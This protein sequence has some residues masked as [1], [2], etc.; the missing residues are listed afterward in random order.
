MHIKEWNL[1]QKG[2]IIEVADLE[3]RSIIEELSLLHQSS[4]STLATSF[5][6]KIKFLII[7]LGYRLGYCGYANITKSI[8]TEKLITLVNNEIDKYRQHYNFGNHRFRNTEWLFDIHWYRDKPDSHYMPQDLFMVCESELNKNRDLKKNQKEL[9]GFHRPGVRYDFQKLLACNANLRLMIFRISKKT[10]LDDPIKGLSVYFTEAISSYNQ[11]CEGNKFL[12]ICFH[13]N[14]LY[15][16][17]Y[18][19]TLTTNS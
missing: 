3:C 5:T 11:L 12:F 13:Q 8:I 6:N 2:Q 16:R 14:D 9:S 4:I 17:Y 7:R 19:K 1:Y 15:Y 10:E 18:E